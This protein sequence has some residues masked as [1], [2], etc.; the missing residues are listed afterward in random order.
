MTT[1][2]NYLRTIGSGAIKNSSGIV[3]GGVIKTS[4]GAVGL[5]CNLNFFTLSCNLNLFRCSLLW[6]N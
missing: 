4:S 5:W 3:G 6:C 1:K 2:K